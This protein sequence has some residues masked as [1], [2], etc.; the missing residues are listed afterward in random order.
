MS[1]PSILYGITS[2]KQQFISDIWMIHESICS[3]CSCVCVCV[4]M[5]SRVWLFVTPWTV[6]RHGSFLARILEWVVISYS[7]G[8]SWPRDQTHISCSSCI[9][10]WILFHWA[11]WEAQVSTQGS[12]LVIHFLHSSVYMSIPITQFIPAWYPCLFFKSVSL[13]LLCK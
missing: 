9:G 13:F 7:R 3:M 5:L 10:W 2:E 4:F 12:P 11:T 6:A 8:S 1:G